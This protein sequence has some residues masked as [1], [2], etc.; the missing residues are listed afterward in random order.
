[1]LF[2]AREESVE[3]LVISLGEE[4]GEFGVGSLGFDKLGALVTTINDLV[5]ED[6]S[7]S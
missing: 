6:E 1:M 7:S 2:L 4:G 5:F 3:I